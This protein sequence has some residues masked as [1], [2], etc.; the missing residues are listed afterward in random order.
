MGVADHYEQIE[1]R[2]EAELRDWLAANYQRDRG[3]WLI[4]HKKHTPHYV[5]W[6]AIVDE[7]LCF[8]W[9][10]GLVRAVDEDRVMHI[11]S[12]RRAGSVW[13]RI[14]KAKVDSLEREGRMTDAGRAVIE[15]AQADGSW[16]LYDA[17]EALVVPADL[18]KALGKGSRA[19]WDAF[20]DSSKKPIL[21]WIQSAKRDATREG[22]DPR[23]AH[24]AHR[25]DG[26]ARPP[27]EPSGRRADLPRPRAERCG[28]GGRPE[29][30]SHERST[31]AIPPP[32][33][34]C[35]SFASMGSIRPSAPTSTLGPPT[36]SRRIAT[37]TS[38][39]RSTSPGGGWASHAISGV[40]MSAVSW[41]QRL[42]TTH[43]NSSTPSPW[44]GTDG[45]SAPPTASRSCP[46][47]RRQR[48]TLRGLPG[49]A[50]LAFSRRP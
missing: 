34:R 7:C 20:S 19:K 50:R 1:I 40:S 14:N 28:R 24:R 8:G 26:G 18:A 49:P 47:R 44:W 23:A 2:T 31:L 37:R 17:V 15:R 48:D 33:P 41:R 43:P 27:S 4:H 5:S 9:V 22:R 45:S 16:T 11:I 21:W 13:S 12:P 30:V 6:S 29:K 38:C 32:A 46:P 10:D 39:S 3:V 25:G 36:R 35:R 42:P